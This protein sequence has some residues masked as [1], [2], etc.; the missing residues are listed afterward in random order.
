MIQKVEVSEEEKM[1]AAIKK[2]D[3]LIEIVIKFQ[4]NFIISQQDKENGGAVA[5]KYLIDF[6]NTLIETFNQ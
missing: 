2:A 6:R 4:P 1:G 5:A 3:S